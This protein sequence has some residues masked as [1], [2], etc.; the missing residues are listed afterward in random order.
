[1]LTNICQ[2]WLNS[3]TFREHCFHQAPV[4]FSRSACYTS[5][6]KSTEFSN[7]CANQDKRTDEKAH[8]VVRRHRSLQ[9]IWYPRETK[10]RNPDH[11]KHECERANISRPQN[12][13]PQSTQPQTASSSEHWKQTPTANS[14]SS[15]E[16]FVPSF[17]FRTR[18]RT[19]DWAIRIYS[20]K[21]QNT[22]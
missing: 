6:R 21:T 12:T 19:F 11:R 4:Q 9:N 10:H 13:S 1:M 2:N 18:Y 17:I 3:T 16:P 20:A 8:T 7:R 14:N 5:F 22:V 15:W